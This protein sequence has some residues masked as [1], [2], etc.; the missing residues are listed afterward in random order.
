M[1]AISGPRTDIVTKRREFHVR[2]RVAS[3]SRSLS[4]FA[5]NAMPSAGMGQQSSPL[6]HQGHP[7]RYDSQRPYE[8]QHPSRPWYRTDTTGDPKPAAGPRSQA[9]PGRCYLLDTPQR[10]PCPAKAPPLQAPHAPIAQLTIRHPASGNT[11][12]ACDSPQAMA[13][14]ISLSPDAVASSVWKTITTLQSPA[15]IST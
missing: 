10:L 9:C 6:Q 12:R 13:R 3:A 11:A 15:S 2:H 7:S 5:T 1:P 14:S 4:R 8:H